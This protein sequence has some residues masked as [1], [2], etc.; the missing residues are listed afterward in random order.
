MCDKSL[1]D[2]C[3]VSHLVTPCSLCGLLSSRTQPSKVTL[4]FIE[5]LDLIF[6]EAA[7]LTSENCPRQQSGS[8]E[9]SLPEG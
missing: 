4:A 8:L 1:H 2:P 3:T 6:P 5:E 7:N 9:D